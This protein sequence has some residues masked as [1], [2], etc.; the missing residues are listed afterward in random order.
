[1]PLSGVGDVTVDASGDTD[2]IVRMKRLVAQVKFI[3]IRNIQF[4]IL[5]GKLFLRLKR[6][7]YITYLSKGSY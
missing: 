5:I 6:I 7:H 2:D 4:L 3:V 1:M